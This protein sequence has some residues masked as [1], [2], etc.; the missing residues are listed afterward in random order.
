V[1]AIVSATFVDNDGQLWVGFRYGGAAVIHEPH[2]WHDSEISLFTAAEGLSGA[3]FSVV[4]DR[5]GTLWA[6]T[7]SGLFYYDKK[8]WQRSGALERSATYGAYIDRENT[9]WVASSDSVFAIDATR[10]TARRVA[11]LP[12]RSSAKKFFAQALDGSVWL[13]ISGTGLYRVDVGRTAL[14]AWFRDKNVGQILADHDGNLWMA[15]DALRRLPP[16]AWTSTAT[17]AEAATLLEELGPTGGLN[18]SHVSALFEDRQGTVWM[19]TDRGIE[20]FTQPSLTPLPLPADLPSWGNHVLVAGP[21]GSVWIAASGGM[22]LLHYENGRLTDRIDTPLL[23]AGARDLDGRIWFAGPKGIGRLDAD[24]LELVPLPGDVDG[25]SVQALALDGAGSAWVSI[26]GRGVYRFRDRQW[27]PFGG[28]PA[29]PSDTALSATTGPDGE[30]WLGFSNNV[31]ARISQ[32][33]V[34]VF[35]AADGLRVGGI[36]ALSASG[37]SLWIGGETGLAFFDGRQI[38]ELIASTCQ[39]FRATFGL[40]E[41]SSGDLWVFRGALSI[42]PDARGQLAENVTT[43]PVGCRNI[44]PSKAAQ[45]RALTPA[46]VPSSDGRIWLAS[47]DA[48]LWFEPDQ[49]LALEATD[50]VARPVPIPLSAP[51]VTWLRYLSADPTDARDQLAAA[52]QIGFPPP[53]GTRLPPRTREVLFNFNFGAVMS[54]APV[55][56]DY[57]LIGYS[58]DWRS[59]LGPGIAIFTNLGPG[60]YRLEA[61][62]Y[63]DERLPD[64]PTTSLEFEI[65]PTFYETKW[66]YTLCGLL[67]VAL[68]IALFRFQLLRASARLRER[69]EERLAERERIARE[70]HDTLLQGIQGLIMNVHSASLELPEQTAVREKLARALD[71]AEG[72]L[73]EGRDRVTDLRTSMDG[74]HDLANDIAAI[75]ER[76]ASEYSIKFSPSVHGETQSLHPIVREETLLIVREALLNAFKHA[77]ARHISSGIYFDRGAFRVVITD[78]GGGVPPQL[79]EGG[80]ERHWG[81][82]GMRERAEKIRGTLDIRSSVAGTSIELHVPAAIAYGKPGASSRSLVPRLSLVTRIGRGL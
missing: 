60:V 71:Q 37:Q 35:T 36:T 50:Y 15:G 52:S 42:V 26:D 74:R 62:A 51:V 9:L 72:V 63:T 40:T 53:S 38:H 76:L 79:L 43:H 55:R 31:L 4:Q 3:V 33:Q 66:F 22:E 14:S 28:L 8:R 48:P 25:R 65:L 56:F 47:S 70:L 32:D 30:V 54:D 61:A 23:T 12:S 78:D 27:E 58:D 57:R 19:A 49:L 45:S 16:D 34:R 44:R 6:T 18:A 11:A 2:R 21:D 24:R 10:T 81:I 59:L 20:R 46:M 29:I 64:S 69:L 5:Y 39:P 77:H 67:C 41:T 73:V 13:S 17:E 7:E 80:R 75:G 82:R 1:S 68:L